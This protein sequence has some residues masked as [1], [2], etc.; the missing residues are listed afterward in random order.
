MKMQDDGQE[1][2]EEV[3]AGWS[4]DGDGKLKPIKGE[5]IAVDFNASGSSSLQ[6]RFRNFRLNKMKSQRQEAINSKKKQEERQDPAKMQELRQ[7]FIDRCKS[8]YGV[9]YA[10]KYHQ[11]DSELYNSKKFLD[12][13]GLVRQVLRD[14][15]NELGF[16]PGP[17]NQAYQFDTLPVRYETWQE[18]KPGDLVFAEGEYVKP[19]MKPQPGNIVHV[20]V[21]LGGGTEGK[22]VCGARWNSGVVQ[23]FDSYEFAA[24]SW[25]LTRWH[26]CSID[27]WL[28]G[29][30]KSFNP[31]R[32]WKRKQ[33]WVPGSRSI[34]HAEEEEDEMAEDELDEQAEEGSGLSSRAGRRFFVSDP[35]KYRTVVEALASK[36]W[37]QI[38][39]KDAE[40]L[41]FDLKWTETLVEVDLARFRNN[42]QIVN[43]IPTRFPLSNF[44]K[45]I[46]TLRSR[47]RQIMREHKKSEEGAFSSSSSSPS[48]SLITS[49]KFVPQ[50]FDVTLST[51]RMHLIQILEEGEQ[52]NDS[53]VLKS[54]GGSQKT[55]ISSDRDALLDSLLKRSAGPDKKGYTMIQKHIADPLLL[56]DRKF[57]IRCFV[58]I[59]QTFPAFKILFHTGLCCSALKSYS[60]DLLEEEVQDP[61]LGFRVGD[62]SFARTWKQAEEALAQEGAIPRGWFDDQLK[63]QLETICRETFCAAKNDLS[64]VRGYFELFSVDFLVDSSLKPWLLRVGSNKHLSADVPELRQELFNIV[65]DALEIVLELNEKTKVEGKSPAMEEMEQLRKSS[66]KVL[67]EE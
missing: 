22:S 7:M 42:E 43:H 49:D 4:R 16:S 60:R 67:L 52:K 61:F 37:H 31:D 53:W 57:A 30:C 20:E 38:T 50:V 59:P 13:C 54:A 12:C 18:M 46:K 17:W 65:S 21:F 9:P 1:A 11:P 47:D 40:N 62:A 66:F 58:L 2:Q 8:Y 5:I 28:T 36:G 6:D 33:Q 64:R 44:N 39:M 56:Q 32:K 14:M 24:K 51:D 19:G 34:F 26:F 10:K 23:E 55:I 29:V 15:K 27:T 45:L 48:S 3:P 25:S 35:M 41:N 63:E